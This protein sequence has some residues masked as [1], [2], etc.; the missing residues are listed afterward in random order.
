M[1]GLGT[2]LG[3]HLPRSGLY[4][5][6][7][8]LCKPAND[9]PRWRI[10]SHYV[11]LDRGISFNYSRDAHSYHCSP[12]PNNLMKKESFS[13]WCARATICFILANPLDIAKLID[14]EVCNSVLSWLEFL[15][16]SFFITKGSYHY[17]RG[18]GTPKWKCRGYSSWRILVTLR[19]S[20]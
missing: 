12:F 18:R 15:D 14:C 9:V 5:S 17:P 19:C 2:W 11:G 20:G 3:L 13:C 16:D 1:F 4:W 7:D 10:P 8:V 6:H